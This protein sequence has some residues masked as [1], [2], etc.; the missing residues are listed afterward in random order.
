M[1]ILFPSCR[2]LLSFSDGVKFRSK[3]RIVPPPFVFFTTGGWER[4]GGDKIFGW[5]VSRA[6]SVNSVVALCLLICPPSAW[7]IANSN[8]QIL[9]SCVFGL[10]GDPCDEDP[11]E[12]P[13]SPPTIRGFL[14]LARWPPSAWN[15]ENCRLQVLHSKTRFG[16]D[17]EED[18]KSAVVEA[19]LRES[20][21]KQFAMVVMLSRSL[22]LFMTMEGILENVLS[23][24]LSLYLYVKKME[25]EMAFL[26]RLSEGIDFRTGLVGVIYI[27]EERGKE[28]VDNLEWQLCPRFLVPK[29]RGSTGEVGVLKDFEN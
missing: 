19:V 12:F 18:S 4:G 29:E 8:P 3:H 11:S 13:P 6:W 24:S 17:N 25:T 9:H 21:I 16:E 5:L 1:E 7:P 23:L 20:N 10:V 14:W 2:N 27:G 15:D 26:F 22:S 28:S